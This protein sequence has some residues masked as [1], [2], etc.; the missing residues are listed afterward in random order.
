[1][2]KT[3]FINFTL[4]TS[5][6]IILF[7]VCLVVFTT[8]FVKSIKQDLLKNEILHN[9]QIIENVKNIIELWLKNKI[10]ILE[11]AHINSDIL[12]SK[13]KKNIQNMFS[14]IKM[15]DKS[16]DALQI[17][18]DDKSF[19]MSSDNDELIEI[20]NQK[21]MLNQ[22]LA[23]DLSYSKDWFKKTKSSLKSQI[24]VVKEHVSL[25]K[26]T[27]NLSIPIIYNNK[28]IAVL[29]GVI[30]ADNLGE[31]FKSM[32]MINNVHTFLV[33]DNHVIFT[34]NINEEIANKIKNKL[35]NPNIEDNNF[36]IDDF[37]QINKYKLGFYIDDTHI[38]NNLESIIKKEI[39]FI[40]VLFVAFIIIS[41]IY[42]YYFVYENKELLHSQKLANILFKESEFGL[43]ILDSKNKINYINKTAKEL[44]K[45]IEIKDINKDKITYQNK[46]Y[47]IKKIPYFKNKLTKNI[48]VTIEDI[49]QKEEL[50]KQKQKNEKIL[51]H[52]AKMIEIGQ[53]IGGINHQLKQP[54]NAINILISNILQ[55]GK[56][57]APETIE[58]NLR[59]CQNQILNLNDTINLYSSYYNNN[60]TITEFNLYKCIQ[61]TILFINTAK[62]LKNPNIKIKGNK[63]LIIKSLEN[64]ISQIMII[65]ISN[66]LEASLDAENKSIIVEIND[67]DKDL[68]KIN[69]IDYANGID[70]E[71]LDSLF[72]EIKTT[73]ERGVGIGLYFAKKLANDKLRGDLKVINANNPTNF[74]LTIPH[75]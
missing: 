72:V 1:M 24:Y 25:L 50:K 36:F 41:L 38:K 22:K 39:I 32:N 62:F 43:V 40:I 51:N 3:K 21:K 57:L 34:N 4:I 13:N 35:N 73:K 60:F 68:I 49:T 5:L 31:K 18:Y 29:A 9:K 65:L 56:N 58:T 7:G 54:I 10:L 66:A 44:L 53:L 30:N 37:K 71:I 46:V 48:I 20:S 33:L 42:K 16:F 70:K 17:L 74:E 63:N 47:I 27:I 69:V 12:D 28:F 64:V 8:L 23:E 15:L 59:L 45:N 2:K 26:T 61:N 75:I 11:S 19:Y 6:A 55:Q 67:N 14:N 52:R